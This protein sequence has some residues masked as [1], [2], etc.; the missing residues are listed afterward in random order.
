MKVDQNN[1]IPVKQVVL[2]FVQRLKLQIILLVYAGNPQDLDTAI[3]TV[4]NIEKGLVIA[5]KSKQVYALED[6]IAQLSKQVNTLA[7]GDF[8]E[9]Q[10]S[11]HQ[12]EVVSRK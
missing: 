11:I 4:R 12:K 10:S 6:Q 1:A 3:T 8:K 5:N 2:K 9:S 7:R